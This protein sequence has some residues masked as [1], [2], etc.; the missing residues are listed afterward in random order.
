[1]NNIG[2]YISMT[3]TMALSGFI[4]YGFKRTNERIDDIITRVN[5]RLYDIDDKIDNNIKEINSIHKKF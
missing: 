5:D 3:Y 4:L 1:M 2:T